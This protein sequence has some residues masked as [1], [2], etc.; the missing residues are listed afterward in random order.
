MVPITSVGTDTFNLSS[1][2][3]KFPDSLEQQLRSSPLWRGQKRY[4]FNVLHDSNSMAN[5]SSVPID[6][7][8]VAR[9]YIQHRSWCH[10]WRIKTRA[11]IVLG[12]DG[13]AL[14]SFMKRSSATVQPCPRIDPC[15][16]TVAGVSIRSRVRCHC[17]GIKNRNQ[18][19]EQNRKLNLPYQW[20]NR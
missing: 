13:S 15:S 19:A 20:S 4:L 18:T 16:S 6:Y 12:G 1:R 14:V 10:L 2:S 7:R 5:V 8:R 3:N 11:C 17:C 9:L